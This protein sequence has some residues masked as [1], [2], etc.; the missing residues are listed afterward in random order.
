VAAGALIC[1]AQRSLRSNCN[2][3]VIRDILDRIHSVRMRTNPFERLQLPPGTPVVEITRTEYAADGTPVEV[4]E[5]TADAGS[6]VF[7]Y[8]F[9]AA[10]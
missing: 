3:G 6:Y 2:L 10:G 9:A 5:M 1:R 7:R 8:E 4:N